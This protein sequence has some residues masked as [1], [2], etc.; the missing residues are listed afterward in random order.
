MAATGAAVAA[1]LAT[2][3]VAH[4]AV[5]TVTTTADSGAGSLRKAIG[6]ANATATADEVRF[7][8]PGAGTKTISVTGGALP[9]L[10]HPVT[11]D[12]TTQPGFAGVPLIRIDNAT[13]DAAVAG[14]RVTTTASTLRALSVTGFG[15]G[16]VLAGAGANVL[17]G[18]YVGIDAGNIAHPNTIGVSVTSDGNTIGGTS[19]AARN[20]ISGN[21]T[22]GIDIEGADGTLVQGNH[23]G[24]NANTSAGI[25]NGA[26]GVRIAAWA[27]ANLVGGSQAARNVISANGAGVHVTGAGS[28]GNIVQGN[29]I[30][31]NA[32]GTIAMGNVSVGVS[33]SGG[34]KGTLIGGATSAAR[35]QVSG[36]QGLG[37]HVGLSSGTQVQGNLIGTDA[38]GAAALP[39]FDSGVRVDGG[40][41]NTVVGSA[42]SGLR[43]VISGNASGGVLVTGE[44]TTGTVVAGNRI[45]TNTAGTAAIPNVLFG[46]GVFGSP[47]GTTVGG[48]GSDARNLI[49]GNTSA[50]GVLVG[51][52]TDSVV[53]GN[54]IGT[55][56]SGDAAL[57][58][59]TGV[60]VHATTSARIGGNAP[61]AGNVIS[62][63]TGSGVRIEWP[64]TSGIV[65]AGN[66]IGTSASGTA[67]VPNDA[68]VTIVDGASANTIGGTTAG[69]GNVIAGNQEDG[70]TVDGPDA[71]GN[72]ILRNAIFDNG[73]LGIE[74][75]N[76]GNDDQP[77][78]QI[79]AVQQ[80]AT[81]TTVKGTLSAGAPSTLHRIEVFTNPACD[82]AMGGEGTVFVAAKNVTTDATGAA[83]WSVS[84]PKIAAGQIVTAT[85]TRWDAV[86]NTSPFSLCFGA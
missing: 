68:G 48:S 17:A 8:I 6:Q 54:Y 3:A 40:A 34:A 72:A 13:G 41:V 44:G 77:A 49:S 9:K 74:L 43:N 63:N 20:V 78:P 86:T 14:L 10:K 59:A 46:V 25:G 39:N 66:R 28:D 51:G 85:A 7:A 57:P 65:V 73:G 79:T 5:F 83:T 81:S 23:I 52:S 4:A 60:L 33:V 22:Y 62:G 42:A 29:R 61:G 1:L 36:N 70:V 21:Q 27:K 19:A 56:A 24:T 37:V 2:P 71:D 69:S 30:G 50:E 53:A 67:G 47:Q 82:G 45:G 58:N 35:N 12:G 32:A 31:T 84:V 75:M 76:G 38:A 26:T 80:R 64:T 15:T 18:S 11:I 55:T 16:V